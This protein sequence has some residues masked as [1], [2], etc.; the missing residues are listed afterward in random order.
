MSTARG[1]AHGTFTA[2]GL[3]PDNDRRQNSNRNR[4]SE[5]H[6]PSIVG[7]R[8]NFFIRERTR[9]SEKEERRRADAVLPGVLE[10][11]D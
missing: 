7:D 5:R 9:T 3:L 8:Y 4:E 6:M 10:A 2:L 1:Q 11:A